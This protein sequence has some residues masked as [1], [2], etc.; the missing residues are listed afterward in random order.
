[1]NEDYLHDRLIALGDMMG[2]GLHHEPDGKWIEKEYNKVFN[3]LYPE[4]KRAK[5]LAKSNRI[6]E[7]IN[8]LILIKKCS[9][10]SGDLKQSR[11]G[12]IICY[13]KKCNS[14]FKATNKK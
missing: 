8:N 6:D 11:K 7:Q 5:R 3:I 9:K 14:R 1:M 2:D 13:C 4:V 12:S 10:C